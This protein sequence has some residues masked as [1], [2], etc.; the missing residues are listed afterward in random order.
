M[1]GR[2]LFLVRVSGESMWPSLVPG[3]RYWATSLLKP[4]VGDVVVAVH[5][6][7]H[8]IFVV[9]KITTH[10]GNAYGLDGTVPWSSSFTV[11]ADTVVGVLLHSRFQEKR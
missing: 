3:R 11:P 7:D 10:D 8:T 9:K 4:R 6:H 2:V 1:L 5:P